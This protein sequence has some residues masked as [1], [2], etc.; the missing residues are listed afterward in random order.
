[1]PQAGAISSPRSATR[2]DDEPGRWAAGRSRTWPPTSL[3]WR[4]RTIARLEAAADGRDAPARPV[5]GDLDDDDSIND[6]IQ[7]GRPRTDRSARSS[8][9]STARTTAGRRRR[10][11]P[12]EVLDR[13]AT[14]LPVAGGRV[15]G[16]N[17]LVRPRPRRAHAVDPCAG[18]P[19]RLAAGRTTLAA[20]TETAATAAT[21][22]E[23]P[24][25]PRPSA[26]SSPASGATP[27]S[28]RD[29]REPQPG[30][31]AR[32][33]RALPAGDRGRRR[34]GHQ[35]R[36]DRLPDVAPHAGAEARRDPVRASAR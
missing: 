30:R 18:S 35:G 32:R 24:S 26:T 10:A 25:R 19:T 27:T 13:P 20:M 4:D 5:A 7:D 28:R 3:G 23:P 36:R 34:D 6:W 21:T 15:A 29:L 1:M 22:A 31:H 11:A 8:T 9:T 12:V 16:R 33:R 17:R 14:A 2:P